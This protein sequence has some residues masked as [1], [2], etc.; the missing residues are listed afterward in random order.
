M[1][2]V[3][4]GVTELHRAGFDDFRG[5]DAIGAVIARLRKCRNA[6]GVVECVE[7]AIHAHAIGEGGCHSALSLRAT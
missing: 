6:A 5:I 7:C 1:R 4:D 3:D 2:A